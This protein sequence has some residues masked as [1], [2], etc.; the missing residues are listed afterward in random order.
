MIHYSPKKK[1]SKTREKLCIISKI[2]L[3]KDYHVRVPTF[4]ISIKVPY[5][6]TNRTNDTK[7][8]DTVKL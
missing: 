4:N 6:K 2:I 3:I 1:P 8:K 5:I 7:L